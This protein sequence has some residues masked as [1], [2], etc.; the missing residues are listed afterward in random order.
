MSKSWWV[1]ILTY[2]NEPSCK[3][4]LTGPEDKIL[5]EPKIHQSWS[6]TERDISEIFRDG[7][8]VGLDVSPGAGTTA[9]RLSSTSCVDFHYSFIRVRHLE[10][11]KIA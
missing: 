7:R 3:K 9:N 6:V 2:L 5:H 4:I 10:V 11:A 1:R 8:Q